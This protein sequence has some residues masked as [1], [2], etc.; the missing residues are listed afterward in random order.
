MSENQRERSAEAERTS[1]QRALP[2][3]GDVGQRRLRDARVLVIGA[4]GLAVPV[5]QYLAGAGIGRL[6]LIDFD[7]V[8][9]SNL[10]RQVLFTAVDIGRQKAGALAAV[11]ARIAPASRVEAHEAQVTPNNAA[12]L[13]GALAPDLVIDTTDHWP[14]RLAIADA[15][16]E[17]AVALVWPS[18]IGTDGQL[19]VFS[20]APG[21]PTIDDLVDRETAPQHPVSCAVDGV[22]GPVVG[23]VG[24]MAATEAIKL[25]VGGGRPL[26]GRVAIIDGLGATV[27]EVPLVPRGSARSGGRDAA[28]VPTRAPS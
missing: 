21:N 1:R 18:V 22:L 9:P 12:E 19:T 7:A 23:Q 17:R 15:C 11:A 4:G 28:G 3:V 8:E 6:D 27:R 5:T 2:W 20:G 10:A 14:T 26:V 13:V 16:R 25:I 24:S